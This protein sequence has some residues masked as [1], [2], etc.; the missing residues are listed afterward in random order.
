MVVCRLCLQKADKHYTLLYSR[1]SL[2]KNVPER[3]SQLLD[4]SMSNEP[5]Y[6]DRVCRGC[7]D[8]FISA[9]KH[10]AQLKEGALKLLTE[11]E[12]NSLTSTTELQCPHVKRNPC[13]CLFTDQSIGHL[14]NKTQQ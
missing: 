6:L 5:G 9:E 14:L 2:G 13:H 12:G 3:I 1:K 4:I 11:R 8:M 10:L 7:S